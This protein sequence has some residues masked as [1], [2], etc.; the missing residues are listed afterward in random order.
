MANGVGP[1]EWLSTTES[2]F[3]MRDFYNEDCITGMARHV[4]DNSVDLVVTDPPYGIA[5]DTLQK[6]Y[7]RKESF[8]IDGYVEVPA[9]RYDEFSRE[10]IAQAARILRPGGA[11]YVVSGYTNLP[12]VLNALRA[13][14]LEEI[15]HIIWKFNFGVYTKT[16]YI[17]SHYHILYYAKPNGRRT[18][19][20]HCRYGPTEK[21]ES[22][23]SLNY[24][25]RE[26]V[27]VINR[28]YQPGTVKNQNHLPTELLVRM[29]QYSSNEGDLICD[30]FMGSFSTARVAIGL[31]RRFV[32]FEIS[33]TIFEHY[34]RE[35]ENW[36]EG[37]LIST[38]GRPLIVRRGR[39]GAPGSAEE[40]NRLARRHEALVNQGFTKQRAV[41][42]LSEEFQRGEWAIIKALDQAA[43]KYHAPDLPFS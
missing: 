15:N 31:R 7:N 40:R 23:E 19:H 43:A 38:L 3:I 6:H 26:D 33:K 27:W 5:G 21:G 8:V 25:D 42:V 39:Q 17:S 28:E 24:R 30:P 11:I 2:N 36:I 32:G 35:S 9:N 22:G 34:R 16:K 1:F 13:C 4:A 12:S 41:K 18:F 29:I 20:T 14:G 37:H 10:W